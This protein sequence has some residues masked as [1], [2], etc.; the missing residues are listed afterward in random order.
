MPLEGEVGPSL[1]GF[2]ICW[3]RGSSGLESGS[4][5]WGSTFHAFLC[6]FS[7]PGCLKLA[8]KV[9]ALFWWVKGGGLTG[10]IPG[11]REAP[12]S[13]LVVWESDPWVWVG[14]GCCELGPVPAPVCC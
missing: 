4:S 11:E 5:R 14:P 8:G 9:L 3:F 12:E 7:T 2:G 10:S 6:T 1:G 13:G